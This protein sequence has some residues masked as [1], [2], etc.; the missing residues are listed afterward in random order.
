MGNGLWTKL[1]EFDY[2]KKVQKV[3]L[4]A[5]LPP[6]E[7]PPPRT[8]VYFEGIQRP[9]EVKDQRERGTDN[10]PALWLVF[11]VPNQGL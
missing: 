6:S 11:Q 5:C 10:H 2:I 3:F 9:V 8:S 4:V 1:D 7:V